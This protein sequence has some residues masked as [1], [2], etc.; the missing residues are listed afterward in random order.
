M[1]QGDWVKHREYGWLGRIQEVLDELFWFNGED[2]G[3]PAEAL[4]RVKWIDAKKKYNG[5]YDAKELEPHIKIERD[6]NALDWLATP[7][8][9]LQNALAAKQLR[10]QR[11]VVMAGRI[12]LDGR[13]R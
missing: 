1:K 3:Q 4:Y 6:T 12:R 11:K 10:E 2:A 13:G 7:R 9:K 8:Q 5:L